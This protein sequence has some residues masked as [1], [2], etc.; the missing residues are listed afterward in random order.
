MPR[1]V[2]VIRTIMPRRFV[3]TILTIRRIM[4]VIIESV[5]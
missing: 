5:L 3:K 2:D 4:I 1:E